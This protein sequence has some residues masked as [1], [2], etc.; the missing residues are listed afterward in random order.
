MGYLLTIPKKLGGCAP[1]PPPLQDNPNFSV[2]VALIG[3][4]YPLNVC[5]K[6][7][8]FIK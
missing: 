5:A 6:L 2:V 7:K 8:I 1:L 4:E 3:N